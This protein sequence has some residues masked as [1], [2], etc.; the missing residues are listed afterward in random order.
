M[1]WANWESHDVY[2]S[3]STEGPQGAEAIIL[4]TSLPDDLAAG[5]A[6]HGDYVLCRDLL[7]ASPGRSSLADVVAT[8]STVAGTDLVSGPSDVTVG[9]RAATYVSFFLTYSVL[10]NGS[11]CSPGVFMSWD[12]PEGGAMW[13]NMM[14]GDTIR[15]WIVDVD[16][17]RLFIEAATHWN[18]DPDVGLEIQQIVDSIQF[19]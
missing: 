6:F 15:V 18:A 1:P 19:E 8:V 2:M 7:G 11:I 16:G 3:K 17:T 14:A 4:W 5:A 9:G 12:D 10:G 13:G